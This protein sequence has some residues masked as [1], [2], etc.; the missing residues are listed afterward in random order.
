MSVTLGV[1]FTP[2]ARTIKPQKSVVSLVRRGLGPTP[3]RL[4]L[5]DYSVSPGALSGADTVSCIFAP[6]TAFPLRCSRARD[7]MRL[8]ITVDFF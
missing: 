1:I 7:D 2:I 4:A 3:T 8:Y 5:A 6:G